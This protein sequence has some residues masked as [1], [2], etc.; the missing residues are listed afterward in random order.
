MFCPI[1][2]SSRNH[3][4]PK[5]QKL[6][7]FIYK[8]PPK[9]VTLNIC[10]DI[11]KRLFGARASYSMGRR[12]SARRVCIDWKRGEIRVTRMCRNKRKMV[13]VRADANLGGSERWRVA[14]QTALLT[15]DPWHYERPPVQIEDQYRP[16]AML[17]LWYIYCSLHSGTTTIA[18]FMPAYEFAVKLMEFGTKVETKCLN[19][20][21]KWR[22]LG[23][24]VLG[25]KK[26]LQLQ[27]HF[28]IRKLSYSFWRIF[29]AKTRWFGNFHNFESRKKNEFCIRKEICL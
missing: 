14:K 19:R 13:W 28:T 7:Q 21:W 22:R 15:F 27:V 25:S 20:D 5:R 29:N 17:E 3:P 11:P 8:Y 10:C 23:N 18:L 16:D 26:S 2:S 6:F 4:E 12:I 9:N 1:S 24:E